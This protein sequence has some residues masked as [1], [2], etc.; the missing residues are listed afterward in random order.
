MEGI[1]GRF[2]P[3]EWTYRNGSLS[4]CHLVQLEEYTQKYVNL[5][6]QV[7]GAFNLGVRKIERVENPYLWG[8]YLLRKEEL[9][10]NG[11]VRE[12]ELFHDTSI[13]NVQSIVETNLDWRLA[14]RVKYGQGV[15]FSQSPAYANKES[16][17][18]NGTNRAFILTKVL[19]QNSEPVYSSVLL[20]S[21][22]HDTT[23]GNCGKVYVKY[24]DDEF[25]PTYIIYY[26]SR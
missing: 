1:V 16:S 9:E 2:I 13:H 24:Y 25:Y 17:R 14:R 3:S 11:F 21:K 4:D 8:Q 12:M 7:A 26:T 19:V 5:K 6:Q 18:S 20:P 10:T 15:S 23:V 22:G